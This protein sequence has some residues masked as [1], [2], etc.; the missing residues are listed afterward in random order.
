MVRNNGLTFVFT[1]PLS[2][3]HEEF[4]THHA[5]HGDGVKDVAFSVD[6]AAG[7]YQK[8]VSRGAIGVREPETL[9]DEHGTVVIA[10][11]KTYGD[12]IHSFVQR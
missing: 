9:T 5:K 1:S 6:D 10:S 12:T 4:S 8:A 7:I 11:V 3:D 2:P